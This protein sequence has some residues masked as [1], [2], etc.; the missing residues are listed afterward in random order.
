MSL[1]IIAGSS[2]AK[3]PSDR[4]P[5]TID[6]P[7]P[8]WT[9]KEVTPDFDSCWILLVIDA[10]LLTLS[11]ASIPKRCLKALSIPFLRSALTGTET[12]TFPSFLAAATVFSQS[13]AGAGFASAAYDTSDTN[14]A[15]KANPTSHS[16]IF[17]WSCIL[18]TSSL[19]LNTISCHANP[20]W[21]ETR[22][23]PIR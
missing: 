14:R 16:K 23:C 1:R 17:A 8:I 10:A 6:S 19:S 12:T 22:I 18:L 15:R 9:S 20:M 3:I 7:P 2:G 4:S 11:S 21:G 13:P 5:E